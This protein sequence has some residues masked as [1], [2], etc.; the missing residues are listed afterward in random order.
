V[1]VHQI[2]ASP[3]DSHLPCPPAVQPA[4]HV[5]ERDDLSVLTA[6]A[7]AVAE[8]VSHAPE[9][10]GWLRQPHGSAPPR[11][12]AGV[13]EQLPGGRATRR[14]RPGSTPVVMHSTVSCAECCWRCSRSGA[15]GNLPARMYKGRARSPRQALP[16]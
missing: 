8:A 16:S 9:W 2:R 14:R 10:S 12:W 13:C 3:T 4:P 15:P 11:S 5:L 6:W 7:E 1:A